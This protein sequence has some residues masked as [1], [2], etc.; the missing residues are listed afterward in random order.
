MTHSADYDEDLRGRLEA[1]LFEVAAE[2]PTSTYEF[3]T[4]LLDANEPGVALETL[5]EVLT[6]QGVV[7]RRQVRDRLADLAET[8]GLG[9]EFA[10]RLLVSDA[11]DGDPWID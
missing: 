7:V 5:S 1:V 9:P 8:M 2:I 3:V 6:D 11:T 10:G 4:E